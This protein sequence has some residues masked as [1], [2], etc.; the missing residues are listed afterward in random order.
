MVISIF[1]GFEVV[2]C[3]L[4]FEVVMCILTATVT[5]VNKSYDRLLG[6]DLGYFELP[7]LSKIEP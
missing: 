1:I 6:I 3:I 5:L 7:L 4:S 2:M